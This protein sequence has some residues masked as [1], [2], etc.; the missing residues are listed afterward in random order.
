MW[1]EEEGKKVSFFSEAVK[2]NIR[3]SIGNENKENFVCCNMCIQNI[4]VL[5]Y[6]YY[7]AMML[8]A[9]TGVACSY[10]C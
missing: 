9:L 8:K 2:R 10:Y 6:N 4:P 3:V 1:K 7:I 5:H